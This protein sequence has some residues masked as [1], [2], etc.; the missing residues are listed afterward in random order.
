MNPKAGWPER[1]AKLAAVVT[2]ALAAAHHCYANPAPL[3]L[4]GGAA[5]LNGPWQFRLGDDP[6]WASPDFDDSSWE[7]LA[8]DKPWGLQGH[9]NNDGFAWYRRRIIIDNAPDRLAILVPAIEDSYELYWNGHLVGNYGRVPPHPRWYPGMQPR[10]FSLGQT[11]SGVLAIRV[12]KVPF[13]SFE[14]GLEGGMYT[15]PI[16]GSP[17]EIHALKSN[18]NFDWLRSE[19]VEIGVNLLY[20]LVAI[21]SL[22]AWM[23]DRQHRVLFWAACFAAS[24]PIFA[25]IFSSRDPMPGDVA[26][27]LSGSFLVLG[28]ISLWFL[29]LWLLDL[30]RHE[31]LLKAAKIFAWLDVVQTILDGIVF[32][33]EPWRNPAPWQIADG[34]MTVI[35]TGVELF[36][37]FIL[38]QAFVDRHRLTRARWMVAITAFSTQTIFVA[39]FALSQGSRF[40]HWT[41]GQVINEPLFTIATNS[42]NALLISDLLLLFSIVYALFQYSSESSR[43]QSRLE[44][45]MQNARE[46]QLILIPD[47]LPVLSGFEVATQYKPAGEVGGDF[48]QILPLASGSALVVIGDVSGK[49]MPAAMTVSL[50]VGTVRTLAHYIHSPGAILDAM[51]ARLLARSRGFTTCLV[52][53]V[54]PHGE[55]RVASAGHIPP[56][57]DGREF[58]VDNGLP[59]G[60]SESAVYAESVFVLGPRSQ[61]TLLTDGV[62]E[63]RRKSGEFFG[64]ERTASISTASAEQI[65][66]TAQHFGQDDDIT[67]LTLRLRPQVGQQNALA[68][69]AEAFPAEPLNE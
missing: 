19:Q 23:H 41:I 64:L 36:P 43:H 2:L 67:V 65:A 44:Q 33:T 6:T 8:P 48:F 57:V 37:F 39:S 53:H 29:L 18:L 10:S 4:D 21:L 56:Y 9:P 1:L 16:I 26:M 24:K 15:P 66:Q 69:A 17:Q 62:P 34:F 30:R 47:E 25:L 3:K 40:T 14:S 38:W 20:A 46:V 7:Q 54:G 60:I 5:I 22:V 12:W 11:H 55:I 63:A 42:V 59:L 13:A 45:E 49:G 61:I 28:D 58:E 27:A 31:R 68:S 51:N 50:L 35:M 32:L 52:M